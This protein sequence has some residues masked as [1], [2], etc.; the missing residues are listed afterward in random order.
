MS[1]RQHSNYDIVRRLVGDIEPT[2]DHGVD[3]RRLENLRELATL[4]DRLL[5]DIVHVSSAS[6]RLEASMKAIG[7]AAEEFIE[8]VKKSL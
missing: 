3:Q 8:E 5:H 1:E 7:V 2:G 6:T 4:V